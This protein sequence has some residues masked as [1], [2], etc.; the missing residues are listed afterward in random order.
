MKGA[1]KI[2]IWNLHPLAFRR[3][4]VWM[5]ALDPLANSYHLHLKAA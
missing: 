1:D 3:L 5:F 2:A 4:V